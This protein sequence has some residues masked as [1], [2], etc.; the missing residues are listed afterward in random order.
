MLSKN[1][2]KQTI[3]RGSNRSLNQVRQS[4]DNRG[5]LTKPR[6]E[7]CV[8]FSGKACRSADVDTLFLEYEATLANF[9]YM[10]YLA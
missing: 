2:A 8:A 7:H 10:K 1:Y 9:F 4:E 6:S 5:S 3:V